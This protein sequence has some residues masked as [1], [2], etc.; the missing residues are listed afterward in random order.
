MEGGGQRE[1]ELVYMLLIR[2]VVPAGSLARFNSRL[3]QIHNHTHA[4]THTHTHVIFACVWGQ[5]FSILSGCICQL[6]A[7]ADIQVPIDSVKACGQQ[8]VKAGVREGAAWGRRVAG[9]TE[10]GQ[11]C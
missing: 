10:E 6:K 4:Q 1:A 2:N 9:G 5:C 11:G 7:F 8:R 3:K